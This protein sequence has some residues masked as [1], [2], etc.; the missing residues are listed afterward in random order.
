VKWSTLKLKEAQRITEK[1]KEK[2]EFV[3]WNIEA[4][5][6]HFG[7]IAKRLEGKEELIA[8]GYLCYDLRDFF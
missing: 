6:D 3:N 1:L 8:D 7:L 2:T 4:R 5:K